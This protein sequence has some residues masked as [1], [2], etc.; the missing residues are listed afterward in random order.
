MTG[1]NG[2][3][4]AT[5]CV[6]DGRRPLRTVSGGRRGNWRQRTSNADR[7]GRHACD[8]GRCSCNRSTCGN[9]THSPHCQPARR[10]RRLTSAHRR[11]R[12]SVRVRPVAARASDVRR[13]TIRL[14]GGS[15]GGESATFPR[16]RRQLRFAPNDLSKLLRRRRTSSSGQ[17]GVIQSA[18]VQVAVGAGTG[19][20]PRALTAGS[21]RCLVPGGGVKLSPLTMSATRT[22]PLRA[23][24]R[25]S[26]ACA[27]VMATL[28]VMLVVGAP[29]ADRSDSSVAALHVEQAGTSAHHAHDGRC[30]I[31]AAS[32]LVAPP[33]ARPDA[34][35][36]RE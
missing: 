3:K 22:G 35:G 31:C 32:H 2:T 30:I 33:R 36:T 13:R 29:L 28:H 6:R 25:V 8:G 21:R 5:L 15:G 11:P 7:R 14:G 17:L 34:A 23:V 4:H 24:S 12:G 20:A 18:A 26:R 1:R 9:T 27:I 10:L 16:S 19:A